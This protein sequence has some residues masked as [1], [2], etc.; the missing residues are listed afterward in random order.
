M[1][2][3]LSISEREREELWP[4]VDGLQNGLLTV[5]QRDRLESL[6][7]SN[8]DAATFCAVYAD[9]HAMLRWRFRP[10]SPV[11]PA[12]STSSPAS[13]PAPNDTVTSCCISAASR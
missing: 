11:A 9:L 3:G 6:I 12:S 5:E 4:L 8:D 2:E 10:L 13:I 7:V 1:I